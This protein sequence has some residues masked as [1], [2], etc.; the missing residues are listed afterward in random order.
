MFTE[1]LLF[2]LQSSVVNKTRIG[3]YDRK[4]RKNCKI[5]VDD[6]PG[7]YVVEVVRGWP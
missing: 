2:A 4:K 3:D 6:P 5:L 7:Q 1:I